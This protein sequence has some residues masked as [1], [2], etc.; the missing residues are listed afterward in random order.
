MP[1]HRSRVKRLKQSQK[2]HRRNVSAKRNLKDLTKKL[3]AL[4]KEKKVPEAKKLLKEVTSAYATT[5]KRSTIHHKNAS[6]HISRLTKKVNAIAQPS[7]E[8]SS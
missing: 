6:R 4:V 8:T 5:A 1:W 2:H 7:T 3:L